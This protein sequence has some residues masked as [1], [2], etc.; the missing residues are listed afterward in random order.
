MQKKWAVKEKYPAD[1]AKEFPGASPVVLQLL[2][3]RGINT[4]AAIQE[5]L[6]PDYGKDLH[7]PF[8]FRDM[9]KAVE[10]L[11]KAIDAKE[12]IF[13]FADYDADGVSAGTILMNTLK[14]YGAD[15]GIYIPHRETEGYGLSAK[16]VD[17]ISAAGGKLIITCDCGISSRDEIAAAADRGIEVMVTDHHMQPAKLP[18]RA[19]AL[20]HPKLEGETY[21]FKGLSGGGVAFK[22]AQGLLKTR[23]P[24]GMKDIEAFEKRL[25]ELA[26]ISSVA[27]MV[28]LVG[29]SRT[30]VHFGLVVLN[31]TTRIGLK[32]LYETAGIVPGKVD[33]YSIGFQIAPRINAAGRMDHANT[34]F[35]LLNATDEVE[36]TRLAVALNSANIERQ[37]ATQTI[38]DLARE[39]VIATNQEEKPVIILFD[40]KWAAGLI[41]LVAGK[42]VEEFNRPVFLFTKKNDKEFVGSGRSIPAFNIIIAMQSMPDAF[43]RFGGHPG[44]AGMSIEPEKFD[45]FRERFTAHA[46]K[47]L[48]D[49]DL[50]P[51]LSIDAELALEDVTWEL[52]KE[53]EKIAPCGM[54]NPTP[55]Y[56]ARG[57]KVIEAAP[58]GAGGKHMRLSVCHT[59]KDVRKCIAFS[60]GDWIERLEPG[61]TVDAVFEVGVNEWNGN[62]ELQLK[63]VDLTL[64]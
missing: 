14:A 63:I 58:V 62:R 18:D 36:A 57:L 44:A 26:A 1:F 50:T 35:A 45:A 38:V 59:T 11:F 32:K 12:K 22:L 31:K 24:A 28:P 41:G 17:F 15:P 52:Q 8:L 16:A 13:I 10:R 51:T 40:E 53:L 43:L 42:L 29:E 27:D 25:T 39:Q 5:F 2:W 61:T 21:P 30:L 23:I 19:F 6:N 64:S 3:N 46:A 47:E 48:A 56:V 60:M 54:N 33:T 9:K 49:K 34:A 20:I 37:K 55:K 7:D 4:T